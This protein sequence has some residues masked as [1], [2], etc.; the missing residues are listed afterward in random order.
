M[1]YESKRTIIFS[2]DPSVRF[3]LRKVN[4][5]RRMEYDLSMA[6]NFRKFREMRE[7]SEP[8]EDD[9]RQA[10]AAA[11]AAD[12]DGKAT[13]TYPTDKLAALID[14]RREQSTYDF[15]VLTPAMIRF[16][17]LKIDGLEIDGEPATVESLIKD[18]PDDLYREIAQAIAAE[19]GLTNEEKENL[20]SPG[21]SEP[22]VDGPVIPD[23]VALPTIAKTAG[24]AATT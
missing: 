3:T 18:G 23:P 1:N 15:S 9:Y 11:R 16:F 10:L 12:S 17:L 13:F 4:V 6:E 5:R 2:V 8:M 7:A 22:P 14:A 20:Q 19:L 21:T 24:S